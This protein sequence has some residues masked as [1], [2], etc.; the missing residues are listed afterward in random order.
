MNGLMTALFGGMNQGGDVGGMGMNQGGPSLLTSLLGQVSSQADAPDWLKG[1]SK[2][3]SDP[4]TQQGVQQFQGMM[5]QLNQ[6]YMDQMY[7][8]SAFD[9][10]VKNPYMDRIN[11]PIMRDLGLQSNAYGQANSPEIAQQ[12]YGPALQM[13]MQSMFKPKPAAAQEQAKQ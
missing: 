11:E 4:Q 2:W 1:A 6:Q 5:P 13:F 7:D 10:R 9:P 8:R 12:V 3:W